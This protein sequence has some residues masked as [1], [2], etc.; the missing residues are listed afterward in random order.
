VNERDYIGVQTLAFQGLE[1]D[2][3]QET[4][5]FILPELESHVESRPLWN[6]ARFS[7]D[8]GTAVITRT[9]GTESRRATLRTGLRVPVVTEGG[10][11]LEAEASLR[12]DAYSVE[13]A[14]RQD[15]SAFEG[16]QSR[17]VPMMALRW[18]YPMIRQVHDASLILEPLA[19]LVTSS[20]GNN[21]D[22]IPNED[23]LTPEFSDTNLF[24]DARFAGADRIEN[25]TRLIY[26]MR[27]QWQ[28]EPG[29]NLNAMLG[30]DYHLSGDPVFPLNAEPGSDLS[31][32]VGRLG[33]QYDPF[34][35]AYR[36]RFDQDRFSLRQNE[37]SANYLGARASGALDY[38]YIDEDPFLGTRRHI[39]GS[40]SLRLSD[41]WTWTASGQKDLEEDKTISASTGFLF[42]YD[43]I[44]VLTQLRR[45][46]IRD[47]DIEP[48]TSLSV[49]LSLKNLN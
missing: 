3:R 12:T 36:F 21:P 4:I 16:S 23:S 17:A 37:V 14:V 18:R 44:S 42:Y 9:R 7:A 13:Q 39:I 47:R 38:V 11:A 43:C 24:S 25:G 8:V 31:D 5:P 28:F 45:D 27:G 10:H 30:Q 26:G 15:G 34:G 20:N 33:M 48:D 32:Y 49:R 29:K 35:L 6:G 40:G 41:S 2:D 19:E 1:A 46:Y 22:T